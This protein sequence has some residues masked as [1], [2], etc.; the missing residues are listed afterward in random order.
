MKELPKDFLAIGRGAEYVITGEDVIVLVSA[1]RRLEIATSLADKSTSTVVM[2]DPATPGT[3]T[4]IFTGTAPQ[5]MQAYLDLAGQLTRK[6]RASAL[7][8]LRSLS[9]SVASIAIVTALT[10]GYLETRRLASELRAAETVPLDARLPADLPP[11]ARD[12]VNQGV[13][14]DVSGLKVLKKPDFLDAPSAVAP[15]TEVPPTAASTPANAAKAISDIGLPAYNPNLYA[16]GSAGPA[17]E[18][19]VPTAPGDG[20][21]AAVA[22]SKP[23][24]SSTSEKA[25]VA[26]K[27]KKTVT[28]ESKTEA[29][30]KPAEKAMAGAD[31][32]V[33]EA[34]ANDAKAQPDP[35]TFQ[36]DAEAA[37]KRL[38]GNGMSDGDV[39]KLLLN[40]QQ[41]NAGG[42]QGITPD[43]LRALPEEVAALLADQG[44]D[45]EGPAGGTMNILPS[46]V[47]DQ[48]RGKDGVATI[49]EN[50]SWY[51]R[52]GGPV[53]IPLPGGGDIKKPDDFK[54]FGLRP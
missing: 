46:E 21:K 52:S 2:R 10:V 27:D 8:I 40:L 50:Y 1:G 25:G 18:A 16:V 3:E 47:V 54:D 31:Q 20:E 15:A 14:P 48:F 53:S 12:L 37:V 13:T 39:R 29:A 6:K 34:E 17:K 7:A 23:G 36:K 5:A 19:D 30:A 41:L 43:M 4:V 11:A 26:A 24:V 35:K 42:D 45:L 22:E 32:E 33:P 28:P 49:P 38:I 44:M 51:A 9:V